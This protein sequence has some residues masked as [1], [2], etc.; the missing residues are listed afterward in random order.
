MDE[1]YK[2]D[3]AK[4]LDLKTLFPENEAAAEKNMSFYVDV[5]LF[6]YNNCAELV[7]QAI[8]LFNDSLAKLSK[9]FLL[10]NDHTLFAQN[11]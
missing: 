4:D 2:K 8:D 1:D 9:P 6:D 5:I 7:S 3:P 11:Y 10:S